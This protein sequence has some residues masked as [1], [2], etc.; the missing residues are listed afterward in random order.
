MFLLDIGHFIGDGVPKVCSPNPQKL[1]M[2][3]PY[4]AKGTLQT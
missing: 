2:C 3:S 4:R 1:G